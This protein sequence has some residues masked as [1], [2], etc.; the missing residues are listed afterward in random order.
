MK[1]HDHQ[2]GINWGLDFENLFLSCKGYASD[3]PGSE[4]RKN[5]S[6]DAKKQNAVL[7]EDIFNPY[8]V[9][10]APPIF[11]IDWQ[12][13]IKPYPA[14]C[15]VAGIDVVKVQNTIDA[16]G[17][18]CLRLQRARKVVWQV[19]NERCDGIADCFSLIKEFLA[20]D[21]NNR[22]YPF[23]TTSR[24]YFGHEAETFLSIKE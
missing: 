16:L 15:D 10:E 6:C 21:K 18:N 23:F 17:L 4:R 24:A 20:P 3:G 22:L 7:D 12:G 8:A 14:N 5:L 11:L 19:L 2:N 9:P 13:Q 1:I